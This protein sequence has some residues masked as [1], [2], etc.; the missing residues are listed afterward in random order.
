MHTAPARWDIF[1]AVVDNYGDIGVTWRLARQL[2]AEHGQQVR[3]WVDE[4]AALAHLW[5]AANPH[6]EQQVLAGVDVW[7]WDAQAE[8]AEP[9]DVVIEAFACEL[10]AA[11]VA[12]MAAQ[13]RPPLWLNLE[14]LSAED[15]VEG[16]HGL[17][18][19]QAGLKKHF[20]FPGFTAKT[21]GL[22]REQGLMAAQAGFD[23]RAFLQTLNVPL[24]QLEQALLV[25][26]FA[27]ADAPLASLLA[28]WQV[29]S[30]PVIAL[31]PAGR[32]VPLAAQALGVE[33]LAVGDVLT[34]GA[35]T[36]V[37]LPFLPQ[38]D[39]DQLLW[40]CDLN[41]VR[42]EDSFVRAQW[43]AAPLLWHIYRQ[44]DDAHLDKLNAF[45]DRYVSG[46]AAEQ[47]AL[48]RQVQLA[49]N[50]QTDMRQRW[51]ELRN[52]LP[53]LQKHHAAWRAGLMAQEDAA[54][55]LMHF[56]ATWL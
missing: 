13:P 26:L 51:P 28:A 6:L 15:W 3:L 24:A 5:P 27:Y 43:A 16:C 35:L 31:L 50:Q 4:P 34:R 10:P 39:Y 45:L 47:A 17:P 29:D 30:A 40:S 14:Y 32:L 33:Q 41:F 56:Y 9:P 7:R 21:G 46:L 23:R 18:S 1:C 55:K 2:V 19:P 12:R 53:V 8:Q 38:D 36:L 11:Y 52:S 44:A 37:V 22:L 42:G 49:W 48:V 54:L 25:S 20:F